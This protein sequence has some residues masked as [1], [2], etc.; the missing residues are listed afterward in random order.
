MKKVLIILLCAL[1]STYSDAQEQPRQNI[2]YPK[3]IF[4]VL[5]NPGIGFTTFNRFNGDELNSR[6][7]WMEGYQ[8]F[9]GN[10]LIH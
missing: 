4:D 10:P 1:F 6:S 3:E 9:D 8:P 5:N 2:K 7:R